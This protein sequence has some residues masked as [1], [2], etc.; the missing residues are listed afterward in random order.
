MDSFQTANG[1]L[2][3]AFIARICHT[4][5]TYK[6]EAATI[7]TKSESRNNVFMPCLCV[8]IN[9]ASLILKYGHDPLVLYNILC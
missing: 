2:C 7:Q 9:Q 1:F 3:I 4:L 6:V 5:S 8:R